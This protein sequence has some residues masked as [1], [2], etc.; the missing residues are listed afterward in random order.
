[1]E[2]ARELI[3]PYLKKDGVIGI[4]TVGRSLR[5]ERSSVLGVWH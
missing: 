2:R 3:Q 1:M 5:R 4:R